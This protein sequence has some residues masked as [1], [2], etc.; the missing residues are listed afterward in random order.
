MLESLTVYS[1]ARFFFFK[2]VLNDLV[3]EWI[4]IN[5]YLILLLLSSTCKIK[6][7]HHRQNPDK[8]QCATLHSLREKEFNEL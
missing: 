8:R 1:S 5:L 4:L 7:C 2:F 6:T 3:L